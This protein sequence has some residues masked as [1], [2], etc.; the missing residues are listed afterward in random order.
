[1]VKYWK[2]T[3]MTEILVSF[4]FSFKDMAI[5]IGKHYLCT[6]MHSVSQSG[7]ALLQVSALMKAT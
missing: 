3:Q 7:Y 2:Y 6:G 5:N 4:S 1:M